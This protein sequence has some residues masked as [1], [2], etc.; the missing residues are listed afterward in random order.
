MCAMKIW[1][2]CVD[3]WV[4][5]GGGVC[6]LCVY[7]CL[8]SHPYVLNV[9]LQVTNPASPFSCGVTLD[10]LFVQVRMQCSEWQEPVSE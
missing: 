2:V 4:C 6:A 8:T 7:L 1:L 10:S 9:A 5:V 3:G